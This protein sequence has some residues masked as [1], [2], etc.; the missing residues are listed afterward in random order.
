MACKERGGGTIFLSLSCG[1]FPGGPQVD[2][3]FWFNEIIK[4]DLGEGPG[5]KHLVFLFFKKKKFLWVKK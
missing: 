4:I 3:D 2:V 1:Y 5:G